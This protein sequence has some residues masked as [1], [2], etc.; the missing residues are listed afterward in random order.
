MDSQEKHPLGSVNFV[1][2]GL[3]GQG[4]LFLTR[5]LAQAALNRGL[6][7]M[8]AE[9]HGMAQRGGSVVSH[10]RLG[11]VESSLVRTGSAHFLLALEENEAYRNIPFV[12]RGG[13]IYANASSD[14][15]PNQE[16]RP[17]FKKME[18]ACRSVAAG[19]IAMELGAPM[20]SNLALLGYISSF[21]EIPLCS[22]LL[23]KTV[24][25]VSPNRFKSINLKIFDAGFQRGAREKEAR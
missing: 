17:Y 22:E 3:G 23:R 2:G 11:D 24:E 10:L 8:G 18:I 7:F 15:F 9:T 21:E 12:A 1:L 16:V 14:S 5:V 25:Q 6:N 19:N 13:K 20:S 4:I